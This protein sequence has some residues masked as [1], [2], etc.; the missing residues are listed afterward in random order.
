MAI[1]LWDNY[2]DMS[3]EMHNIGNYSVDRSGYMHLY[4]RYKDVSFYKRRNQHYD[5]RDIYQ[6]IK[7]HQGRAAE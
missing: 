5:D 3:E 7:K 2:E 4:D 1:W 6:P